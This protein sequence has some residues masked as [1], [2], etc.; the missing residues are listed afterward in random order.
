MRVT[1]RE[2]RPRLDIPQ[3]EATLIGQGYA[4]TLFSDIAGQREGRAGREVTATCPFCG[5]EKH[6]SY[7]LV[8][9]VWQC[10]VCKEQG[11]WYQYLE[12]RRGLDFRTALQELARAAG[13]EVP[14]YD[15]KLYERRQKRISVLEE[16]CRYLK[17]Q[18]QTPEGRP[19]LDYLRG[20]GYSDQ[21]IEAMELGA[22][23]SRPELLRHLQAKGFS[24]EDLQDVDGLLYGKD[25][26]GKPYEID[27]LAR[28]FPLSV[29]IHGLTGQAIGVAFRTLE[30]DR[31]DKYRY[32]GGEGVQKSGLIGLSWSIHSPKKILVEGVIDGHYVSHKAAEAGS[33]EP[34]IALGTNGISD[35]QIE[36]LK[37]TKTEEL[38]LA[39]D[40]DENGFK[41]TAAIIDKLRLQAPKIRL[42]VAPLEDYAED[43]DAKVDPDLLVRTR[44]IEAFV[45]ACSKAESWSRWYAS[46]TV[47]TVADK[48]DIGS[49][50]GRD[51]LLRRLSRT[52]SDIEDRQERA[53]FLEP[54][55]DL[56]IDRESLEAAAES[57]REAMAQE[58]ILAVK[59]SL[60]SRLSDISLEPGSDSF[61]TR[62]LED[63]LSEALTDLRIRQ[64]PAP[65]PYL[66]EDLL[67]DLL[68]TEDGLLT[69]Y[70]DLDKRLRI[71]QGAITIVAGRPGQGKTT[72]QLNLLV[73]ML[74]EYQ[75]K[76]FYFYSYEE[77]SKHLAV[78]LI[79]ILAGVVLDKDA[80]YQE[81]IHYLRDRQSPEPAIEEAA[82]QF[83]QWTA[84]GRLWLMDSKP[85]AE[86]L[87]GQIAYL[88]K[89]GS[90]GAVFV[91]YVQRIPAP[92][93][94]QRYLEV[95]AVCDRILDTSVRLDIPIILGAQLGRPEKGAASKAIRL[96]N[97]RES[98]DIEQDA[99]LVLGLHC[100]AIEAA[101]DKE[102]DKDAALADLPEDVDMSLYV[103]KN[104]A[105][106]SD[107][108]TRVNFNM[109]TLTISNK[110]KAKGGLLRGG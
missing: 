11:N 17:G 2:P 59:K 105:G 34:I 90:I 21:D 42:Y 85:N 70:A 49:D 96:D 8:K 9:P 33:R 24:R 75:D 30:P 37:S 12:K 54:L 58:R 63:V 23:V 57:V 41:G 3:I 38:I 110:A 28:D 104:R 109:P 13:V 74:R 80:N 32:A 35:E 82:E 95:K 72:L 91:D 46:W 22:Y 6:F 73:N 66:Y 100:K 25:K 88:D 77:S 87:C 76:S 78:K 5:K 108:R 62:E 86:D 14:E 20:R 56:R 67:E 69:G 31:K 50:R 79:M 103:L 106:R 102:E 27:Y 97:L 26:D 68:S 1:V 89:R 81:Y 99:N 53:S 60:Q 51:I 65:S 15:Q 61:S 94:S 84:S 107:F 47:V 29:P 48:E 40:S 55:E 19:V 36:A 16:A 10:L 52:Y 7:S 92:P 93:A 71:P 98:G 18:L 83:E 45:E 64:A 4:R 44:G 101:Q 39:L 43:P